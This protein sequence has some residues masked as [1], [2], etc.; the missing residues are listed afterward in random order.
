MHG[1]PFHVVPSLFC[2]DGF[3]Q[4]TRGSRRSRCSDGFTLIELLVVMG[5]LGLLAA[6]I[7]PAAGRG[8][9]ASRSSACKNNIRQI[10]LANQMYAVDHE[11]YVPA[12]TDIWSQN[13]QRWH[14]T[15][16][17][18]AEEFHSAEG[19]LAPYL[20]EDGLVRRCPSFEPEADGFEAGCGGYGYNQVGVG[21]RAYDMG[22]YRGAGE[23][24]PPSAI[25]HPS[26]TIMFTDTAFIRNQ[27]GKAVLIEYSFAEA[28]FHL[29]AMRAAE[30]Y[31]AEPSIHFRHT[32]RRANVV[33]CD[34]HVS[35][36]TL[37][38]SMGMH[39]Q[40]EDLGWFAG[41]G[42]EYFDPF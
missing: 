15:R 33:W 40:S 12:A 32:D 42:N 38:S 27:G 26:S 31:P 24:M 37:A 9:Q 2:P 35:H 18:R 30:T 10:Y 21:S 13:L 34:G 8:I 29:D 6:L 3:R 16:S 22:S 19:P 1:V 7:I 25:R 5:I 14:G 28:R 23:G 4:R 20:G 41:V 17:S 39:F 36:E 11:Q